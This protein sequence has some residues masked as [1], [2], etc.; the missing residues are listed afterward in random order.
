M[1]DDGS[2]GQSVRWLSVNSS[3]TLPPARL[4]HTQ[5][6]SVPRPL[7]MPGTV[8]ELQERNGRDQLTPGSVAMS[9]VTPIGRCPYSC[10]FSNPKVC[11]DEKLAQ[12]VHY[13]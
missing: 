4:Q 6:S 2:G 11:G 9:G 1:S 12:I 5:N 13:R 8:A 10:G 7:R 3:R